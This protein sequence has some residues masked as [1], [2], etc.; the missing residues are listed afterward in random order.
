MFRRLWVMACAAAVA[1]GAFGL[2]APSASASER[3]WHHRIVPVSD[4]WFCGSGGGTD[5]PTH[6]N[7]Y[8]HY[9]DG[10]RHR[11]HYRYRDHYRPHYRHPRPGFGIYLGVPPIDPY[12]QPR[13]YHR[14]VG[15]GDAHIRWCLAR[16]RSYRP[17]DNTFQPYHGPRQQC[18]S[19]YS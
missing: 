2:A 19:P 8:G 4:D 7:R 13:R 17:R 14:S 16:Y 5:C 9:R 11:D 15:R 6:I 3:N 12:Y 10:Y 1:L 18:W